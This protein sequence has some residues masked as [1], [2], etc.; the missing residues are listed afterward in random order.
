LRLLE[1]AAKIGDLPHLRKL[2]ELRELGDSK[3]EQRLASLSGL[4][5]IRGQAKNIKL[6]LLGSILAS[7]FRLVV[8]LTGGAILK[9]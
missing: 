8:W 3:I 6:T 1:A 2:S 5:L 7:F 4:H 9:P